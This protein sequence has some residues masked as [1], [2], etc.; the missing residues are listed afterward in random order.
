MVTPGT[1]NACCYDLT[2]GG[3]STYGDILMDYTT[4][5]QIRNVENDVMR[6]IEQKGRYVSVCYAYYSINDE[7]MKCAQKIG[8][9]FS[10]RIAGNYRHPLLTRARLRCPEISSARLTTI[11]WVPFR[12]MISALMNCR[13]SM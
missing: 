7:V 4:V 13:G 6:Y 9:E 2:V 3:G 5:W 8:N 12:M 11:R 1:V 10:K